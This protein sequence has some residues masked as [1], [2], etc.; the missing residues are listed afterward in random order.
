MWVYFIFQPRLN[1][2]GALATGISNW[3]DKIGNTHKHTE[4][5]TLPQCRKGATSDK[6]H[7]QHAFFP[8]LTIVRIDYLA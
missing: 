3:R 4:T 7:D 6:K 1:L 8:V 2:I 5:D